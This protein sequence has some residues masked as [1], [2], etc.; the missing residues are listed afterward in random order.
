MLRVGL[1]PFR[2]PQP[3]PDARSTGLRLA[4][5]RWVTQ[6]NHPLTSRVIVNRLWAERF[7]RG[8]VATLANFGH[9]G[10]RPSHPGLLDW[11]A[12]E[13]VQNGWSLKHIHRLMTTSA[14]YRQ[15]SRP[16]AAVRVADP[17][18]ILVSSMPMR[19]MR[20]EVLYDSVLRATG[21]LD[22]TP[23][24]PPDTVEV[25]ESGEVVPNGSKAGFRRAIYLLK[26]RKTPVTILELFDSPRMAPNC[27]ERA[28]STVAPQALQ[29]RNGD[30]VRGHAR[31]LAGRLMDEHP[32]D[33]SAQIEQL[34][35]RVLSRP[36]SGQE[37]RL[38]LKDLDLLALE[39]KGHLD[40]QNEPVPR[41]S[42]AR[43]LALG[44]L[45]HAMVSSAEFLY[46]D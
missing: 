5:A 30:L 19:R 16:T 23:F 6:A 8:I 41:V 35:L 25:R 42:S 10:E 2:P 28:T 45:A 33:R 31:Y 13:L 29:M 26:R 21:R 1:E 12:T 15:T 34:Y 46:V 43:W 11:L 7:G 32:D 37:A 4:L 38:A 44:S 22:P 3:R 9:T 40:A 27:T 36:P 24:G 14:A 17:D 39:W 20:A 18:N